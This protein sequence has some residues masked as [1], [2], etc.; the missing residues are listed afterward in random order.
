MKTI[1]KFLYTYLERFQSLTYEFSHEHRLSIQLI[2][3]AAAIFISFLF[4]FRMKSTHKKYVAIGLIASANLLFLLIAFINYYGWEVSIW[5]YAMF[6]PGFIL[7]MDIFYYLGTKYSEHKIMHR[8]MF[9]LF[10]IC[11]LIFTESVI[12]ADILPVNQM[13]SSGLLAYLSSNI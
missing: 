5:E 13:R 12:L 6:G 2:S 8:V 11:T 1:A 10:L 4:F 7:G 3:L 9:A